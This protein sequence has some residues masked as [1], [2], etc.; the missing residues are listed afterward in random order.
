MSAHDR[1]RQA[2]PCIPSEPRFTLATI[3]PIETVRLNENKDALVAALM[4]DTRYQAI[5]TP[6]GSYSLEDVLT[7]DLRASLPLVRLY[8]TVS[9]KQTGEYAYALLS[10]WQSKTPLTANETRLLRLS[11]VKLMNRQA[12]IKLKPAKGLLPDVAEWILP[13]LN[14]ENL[15]I[16]ASKME[17]ANE[18]S[19]VLIDSLDE[20]TAPLLEG[21]PHNPLK[22]KVTQEVKAFRLPTEG[23]GLAY[24]DPSL[25]IEGAVKRTSHWDT[26]WQVTVSDGSKYRLDN[27]SFFSA[28]ASRN[29]PQV[30]YQKDENIPNTAIGDTVSETI[31]YAV[32]LPSKVM[33]WI[34]AGDTGYALGEVSTKHKKTELEFTDA[35]RLSVTLPAS[36]LFA[37][38]SI[39]LLTSFTVHRGPSLMAGHYYSYSRKTRDN[40]TDYW[41]KQNDSTVTACPV[42]EVKAV[43]AGLEDHVSPNMLILRRI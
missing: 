37:D 21:S 3:C 17:E 11:L 29:K 24:F 6:L 10:K 26:T 9:I 13:G 18:F 8:M 22:T 32:T 19:R 5:T 30:T 4:S 43:L 27:L 40:G 7:L 15:S 42:S 1:W 23:S 16:L 35:D 36:C 31:S 33:M 41:V 14:S 38:P 25:H 20:L 28:Y 2:N 39:Y 34:Q 12:N